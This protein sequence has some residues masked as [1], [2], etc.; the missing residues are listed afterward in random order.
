MAITPITQT[1]SAFPSAPNSATDTPSVFNT[2]ANAFVNHQEATYVGEVNTLATQMNTT[3]GEL[4]VAVATLP[5]GVINDTSPSATNTY[6]SDKIEAMAVDNIVSDTTE[7][8]TNQIVNMV[9]MTQTAYDALATKVA[10]TIYFI[11]G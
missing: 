1:I 7:A 11:V 2:K 8:G 3:A 5:D 4:D 10:S 9:Y 6:S